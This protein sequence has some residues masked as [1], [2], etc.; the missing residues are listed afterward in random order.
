MTSSPTDLRSRARAGADALRTGDARKARALFEQVVAAGGGDAAVWL[1]MALACNSLGDDCAKLDALDHALALDPRNL[2]ALLMKA[3]HLGAAGDG[4]AASAFYSAALKVAPPLEQLSAEAQ[5]EILR[6]Q[7]TVARYAAEYEAHLRGRLASRGF[8]DES[9]GSRFAQSLDILMG[10]KQVYFQQPL[11]FFFPGLPQIQFYDRK[12]FPWLDAVEAVTD[13]IRSELLD[14]LRDEA[15]FVPYVQ[16]RTN[17][18]V[19]KYDGML[20]N[21]SWSAFFLWKDGAIVSENAARCPRTLEALAG[22]PLD[23]IRGRTPSVLFSLL[24]PGARIPPHHGMINTRLICHLPLI[25][26]PGCGFRVGNDTRQWEEGRAWLFDDTIEH[27]AWN[28]G[29]QARVIL[30]FD[31]WRPELSG[32]EQERVAAMFEAID[33]FGGAPADWQV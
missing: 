10:K 16:G 9:P 3:D 2:R 6:A 4:R 33:E 17:R 22:A 8:R 30:L 27:E 7:A 14:V 19:Q 23:R 18:P 5:Q 20:D 1:G 15:A 26:P 29:D 21:P 28:G 12:H 11:Y 31:V 24:R 25:V 13:D 32:E